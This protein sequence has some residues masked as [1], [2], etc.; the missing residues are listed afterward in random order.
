M[1]KQKE[2]INDFI[3]KYINSN[4]IVPS[5]NILKNQINRL[6]NYI[7]NEKDINLENIGNI[8]SRLKQIKLI[9]FFNL[10]EIAVSINFI[11]IGDIKQ[12]YKFD[13]TIRIVEEVNLK[14]YN[15][16]IL[17][18]TFRERIK[19]NLK[20]GI[21]FNKSNER[22]FLK[23]LSI[24]ELINNDDDV[25]VFLWLLDQGSIN[26]FRINDIFQDRLIMI[27]KEKES[28]PIQFINGF[29]KYMM[30]LIHQK[31]LLL[32][33][34]NKHKLASLFWKYNS[35]WY[36]NENFNYSTFLFDFSQ[37]LREAT[38][39]F[40]Q[41]DE[42]I[43]FKVKTLKELNDFD[44]SMNLLYSDTYLDGYFSTDYS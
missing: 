30:Y 38:E 21:N 44:E 29:Y 35:Y 27:E 5:I 14:F 24:I 31:N 7:L 1:I 36:L 15:S 13:D 25:A 9:N 37:K 34:K 17:V 8:S 12:L 10:L 41:I 33:L 4:Y 32:E 2:N 18:N 19:N 20:S 39:N 23:F 11:P 28:I 3:D 40:P 22:Y 6:P 42:A 26:N 16:S 43:S